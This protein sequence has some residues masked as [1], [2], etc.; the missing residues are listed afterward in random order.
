LEC[1]SFYENIASDTSQGNAV[2][3]LR[4]TL[5]Q[6][7]DIGTTWLYLSVVWWSNAQLQQFEWVGDQVSPGVTTLKS[8]YMVG[9]DWTDDSLSNE[10]QDQDPSH[11]L[12]L[13]SQSRWQD[14]DLNWEAEFADPAVYLAGAYPMLANIKLATN[15]PMPFVSATVR[16]LANYEGLAFDDIAVQFD[17]NGVADLPYS[18]ISLLALPANVDNIDTDLTWQISFDGG[19]SFVDFSW[20]WQ[21]F[22]V[23]LGQPGALV[24]L[25]CCQAPTAMRID[26]AT[27][28]LRGAT[29]A[30]AAQKV[31]AWAGDTVVFGDKSYKKSP[32][33]MNPWVVLERGDTGFDCLSLATL[34]VAELLSIGTDSAASW[35]YPTTDGD[36]TIPE[37]DIINNLPVLLDFFL[38][39]G[40]TVNSIEGFFFLKEGGQ[41][42]VGY[43]VVPATG[44]FSPY[45]GAVQNL[46]SDNTGRLMFRAMYETLRS[47]QASTSSPRGGR[48]WWVHPHENEEE[49]PD[50]VGTAEV[51][52]AIPIP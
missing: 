4:S 25:S 7:G 11:S 44:P 39:D 36:A 38:D 3:R 6:T 37:Q 27:S 46:P 31:I 19:Q 9:V 33:S 1:A 42:T 2:V 12:R 15:P 13:V 41:P 16:V 20:T 18:Y 40:T 21:K 34:S 50:I 24:D 48:Q 5:T 52:F 8:Y 51:P 43:T 23:T 29:A 32:Y 45:Q 30:N 14:N 10:N 17:A 49:P 47:I 28:D 35:T 26:R 22:W